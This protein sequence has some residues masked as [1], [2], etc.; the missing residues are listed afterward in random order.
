MSDMQINNTPA[1]EFPQKLLYRGKRED[2]GEWVYG[3]YHFSRWYLN[4]VPTGEITHYILPVGAGDAYKVIPES[5]GLDSG[6]KAVSEVNNGQITSIYEGDI[7][8]N[9]MGFEQ[10]V[11][12][13]KGRFL[14]I[15]L[16]DYIFSERQGETFCSCRKKFTDYD[17][18]ITADTIIGNICDNPEWLK[19]EED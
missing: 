1:A 9:H 7:V 12:F 17:K 6:L 14:F 5:V 3:F 10:V 16:F 15:A 18:G 8:R 2:T 19:I 11:A 4:G 13:E